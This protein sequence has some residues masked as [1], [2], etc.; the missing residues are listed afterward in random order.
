MRRD[1][2]ASFMAQKLATATATASRVPQLG[3]AIRKVRP[4]TTIHHASTLPADGWVRI[5]SSLNIAPS[6]V[7]MWLRI[8]GCSGYI[9]D[10][11]IGRKP[12]KP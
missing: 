4:T 6:S 11:R 8:D 1:A 12:T 5:V 2:L 10:F 3:K 9:E 7:E